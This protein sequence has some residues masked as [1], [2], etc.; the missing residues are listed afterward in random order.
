M[1][2]AFTLIELLVV[3]AIIAIL[4]AILFPVFAQAKEAAKATADLSNVK[5]MATAVAIYTTDVDDTNPLGHG[6][7]AA[8]GQHGYNFNKFVPHDWPQGAAGN[9]ALRIEFSS[10]FF[11]NSMQPYIKNYDMLVAPS[12]PKY[13]YKGGAGN[14]NPAP[15]K[16]KRATTYAYNGLLHG[17]SATAIADPAK[18]PLISG[19]NGAA[20]T[21]GWGFA[22]PA[23]F[24]GTAAAAC[25]YQP[26]ASTCP[27][28]AANPAT[29]PNGQMSAMYVTQGPAPARSSYW[30][31][32]RG[33]NWAF[34]D[35]HAKFRKVGA[36]YAQV[37]PNPPDGTPLTD[38]RNDPW[39]GYDATGRAGFY[40]TDGWGCHSFLFRP[41]YD[42][43]L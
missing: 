10:T 17:Y 21:L 34:N 3:I 37:P 13:D 18:S 14:L 35:S 43:S 42:F 6:M 2:R 39:T 24:C 36:V 40:W 27:T 20:E 19:A 12:Q 4:A 1:R 30:F 7:A 32:K 11:M 9:D 26:S 31:F 22:N 15:G 25:S 23:L 5:Q 41:D 28:W 8:T 33:Q 38:W 16:T 29:A